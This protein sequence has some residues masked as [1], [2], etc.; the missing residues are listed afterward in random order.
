VILIGATPQIR[1]LVGM[2][3]RCTK[4]GE[5]KPLEAFVKTPKGLYGYTSQCRPCRAK[6]SCAW[7]SS[8]LEH[9]LATEARYREA[10]REK[11]STYTAA[12]SERRKAI[13][14]AW[15]K[16]H[17]ERARARMARYLAKNRL[18]LAARTAAWRAANPDKFKT[19][20]ATARARKVGAR[21]GCRK[22]Y[23][24]FVSHARTANSID[25]HWCH[26][27]TKPKERHVDHVIPL[28][29][30]GADAVENLCV[31]CA[32]CNLHK[33]AKMPSEFMARI[34]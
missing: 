8:N 7:R 25:C 19:Q 14:V 5:T 33:S 12:N 24:A 9:C 27:S 30:G 15:D 11:I 16:A 17:P 29:K 22:A 6:G 13:A 4:C 1:Y 20:K 3:K 26:R 31:A 23:N 32:D 18:K 10:N 28:S 34:A 2:E 21:I